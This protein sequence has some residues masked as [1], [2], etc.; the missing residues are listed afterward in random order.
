MHNFSRNLSRNIYTHRIDAYTPD[1]DT[2]EED[3]ETI[4][5]PAEVPADSDDDTL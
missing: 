1:F 2:F 5:Y 4:N 3:T